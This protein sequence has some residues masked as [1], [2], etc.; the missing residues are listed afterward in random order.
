MKDVSQTSQN[1]EYLVIKN[2]RKRFEFNEQR[3]KLVSLI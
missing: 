3:H 1:E 2:N